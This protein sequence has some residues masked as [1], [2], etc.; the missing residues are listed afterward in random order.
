[1]P[2][3]ILTGTM[4]FLAALI[5]DILLAFS[6]RRVSKGV[7]MEAA[8]YSGLVTLVGGLVTIEYVSNRWYLLFAAVGA[9]IGSFLTVKF[10]SQ[11]KSTK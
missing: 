8:I 4:V 2:F 6:I 9:F 11:I 1:M 10:D 3:N 5:T 7:V